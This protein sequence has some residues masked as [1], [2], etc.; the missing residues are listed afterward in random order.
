[1]VLD[2]DE[3]VTVIMQD[4]HSKTVRLRRTE[5]LVFLQSTERETA[6]LVSHFGMLLEYMFFDL[7]C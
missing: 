5:Q 7:F 1:M 4:K 3:T 2:V 6:P